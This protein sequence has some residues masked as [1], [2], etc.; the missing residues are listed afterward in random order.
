MI[1]I[2]KTTTM[3]MKNTEPVQSLPPVLLVLAVLLV[4]SLSAPAAPAPAAASPERA[5]ITAIE[6]RIQAA[7]AAGDADGVA[8]QYTEDAYLM[9]PNSPSL[10]G[11]AAIADLYRAF[12]KDFK[13][14]LKTEIQEVVVAGDWAFVRGLL[15]S[16]VT[17]KDGSA[18]HTNHGKYLVVARRGA[19]GV[20]RFARDSYNMDQPPGQR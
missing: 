7:F 13:C 15:T 17:P 14:T 5:K 12:F 3:T 8:A 1:T 6:D 19:D 16:T 11:R 20:W 10:V 18:P 4:L 2:T 9:P